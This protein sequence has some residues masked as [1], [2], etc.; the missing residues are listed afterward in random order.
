MIVKWV[1][2]TASCPHCHS[3]AV[4]GLAATARLSIAALTAAGR[5]AT[6]HTTFTRGRGRCEWQNHSHSCNL[7]TCKDCNPLND[8][9]MNLFNLKKRQSRA[10]AARNQDM[11]EA[12]TQSSVR[13]CTDRAGTTTRG[14]IGQATSIV[15]TS[16]FPY[17]RHVELICIP[18]SFYL[19]RKWNG[20]GLPRQL[21]T[22]KTEKRSVINHTL[23]RVPMHQTAQNMPETKTEQKVSAR[24]NS[25][26]TRG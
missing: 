22:R 11:F 24:P 8:E 5:A 26:A 15:R 20:G 4:G 25:K 14:R 2:G 6:T 17:Y 16:C 9:S 19:W 18:S 23:V 7:A 12:S 21:G 1:G 3:M 13:P 10:N